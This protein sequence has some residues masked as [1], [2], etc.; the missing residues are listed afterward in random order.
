MLTCISS[1]QASSSYTKRRLPSS[2]EEEMATS[3]VLVM[4]FLN[5]EVLCSPLVRDSPF[6]CVVLRVGAGASSSV[7]KWPFLYRLVHSSLSVTSSSCS[8]MILEEKRSGE[9][10][11]PMLRC[12]LARTR[13]RDD[14]QHRWSHLKHSPAHLNASSSSW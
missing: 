14:T 12:L 1:T 5:Q 13:S 10:M 2:S 3:S 6:S 4:G 11:R 8:R 9:Q 7:E